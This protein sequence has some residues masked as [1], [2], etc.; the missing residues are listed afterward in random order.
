MVDLITAALNELGRNVR[1]SNILV[2]GLAFRGG[3]KET[4]NS[5][6]IPIIQRLKKLHANVF[7][8]DPL[9]SR[10]EIEGLGAAYSNSFDNM[11]CLVIVTDHKEFREYD[12]QKIGNKMRSKVIVDGRQV[13]DPARVRNLGFVYKGIG[14]KD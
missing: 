8:Y 5:P 6:A 2:L 14:Y 9:F 13:V 10:E 11:D 4:R 7:L 3:V 1:G 12:W